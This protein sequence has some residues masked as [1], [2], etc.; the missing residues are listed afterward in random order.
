VVAEN[1]IGRRRAVKL[2]A[3]NENED[4]D[5]DEDEDENQDHLDQTFCRQYKLPQVRQSPSLASPHN[6]STRH[7]S[8]SFSL[9]SYFAFFCIG[10]YELPLSHRRA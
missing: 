4:E 2:R 9:S 6:I 8:P 5:E 3:G 7:F 1:L 10:F